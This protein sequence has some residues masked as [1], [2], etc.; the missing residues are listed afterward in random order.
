MMDN[1]CC[2]PLCIFLSSS[3]L[4]VLLDTVV[5]EIVAIIILKSSEIMNSVIAK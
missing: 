2:P 5:V 1:S 4:F 3:W